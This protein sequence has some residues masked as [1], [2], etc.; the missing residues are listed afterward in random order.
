MTPIHVLLKGYEGFAT[1]VDL[2]EIHGQLDILVVTVIYTYA[3][4]IVT[5]LLRCAR[6]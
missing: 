3:G 4:A 1:T 2:Q 5:Q 6:Q